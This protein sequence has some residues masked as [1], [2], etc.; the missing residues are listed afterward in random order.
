MP[1]SPLTHRM[2]GG[3]GGG[4]AVVLG[5]RSGEGRGEGAA[6][7]WISS[8]RIAVLSSSIAADAHAPQI[9]ESVSEVVVHSIEGDGFASL[10][11][12]VHDR[13]TRFPAERVTSSAVSLI[14][15]SA[16]PFSS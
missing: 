12:D 9:I 10:A 16:I 8:A 14:R 2:L 15:S 7:V 13:F 6:N 3:G 11:K 4:A 5:E 1:G